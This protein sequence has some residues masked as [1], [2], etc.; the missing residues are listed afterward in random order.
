MID[1]HFKKTEVIDVTVLSKTCRSQRSSLPVDKGAGSG[2]KCRRSET[3]ISHQGK[4]MLVK[5][6]SSK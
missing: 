3:K 4:Q 2:F 6:V 1:Y 5:K